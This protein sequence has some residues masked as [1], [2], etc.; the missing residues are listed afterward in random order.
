L[1]EREEVKTNQGPNAS[2]PVRCS[3]TAIYVSSSI[4]A[5]L[6]A[7]AS[8]AGLKYRAAIY[9]TEELIQAF[10]PSDVVNLAIGL[11][12]LLGSMWLARRDRL[13]G[14]LCWPGALLFVLYNYLV[15]VL[16]MPL[17][18]ALLLHLALVTLSVYTIIGLVATIDGK[19]VEQVLAGA[20]PARVSGGILAGLGLLF[21]VRVMGVL[22]SALSS[23][24][25]IGGTELAL[26]ISDFLFAPALVIGGTL[27]WRRKGF[28]YVSGLGL[29]FQAS[30]LFIGLIVLLL[31]QPSLTGAPFALADV[32]VIFVLGLVCFVPLALFVRGVV[33]KSGPQS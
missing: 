1:E 32:V 8:I 11:P 5:V 2:L 16:A 31:V 30:M 24:T 14:L 9:P 20:V 23:E 29:L 22:I 4:I 21:L 33:S 17:N 25:R 27:L 18:V 7:A 10:V 3:L 12:I 28:G 26:H 13:I 19:A 15:Y 6:V